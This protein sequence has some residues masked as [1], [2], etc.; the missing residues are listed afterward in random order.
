MGPAGSSGIG[1]FEEHEYVTGL[2]G[3]VGDERIG[4]MAVRLAVGD[5][6]ALGRRRARVD[7]HGNQAALV[8]Q[9]GSAAADT[10]KTIAEAHAAL[11]RIVP[12]CKR[13]KGSQHV[14]LL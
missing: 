9:T 2:V 7:Q 5:E 8:F 1:P 6:K 14:A 11:I 13:R 10:R 3:A 12:E 4:H